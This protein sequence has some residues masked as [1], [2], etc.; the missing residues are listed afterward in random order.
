MAPGL[1]K[2]L[3]LLTDTANEAA[4]PVLLAALD[5]ADEA[6]SAGALHAI[7]GRRRGPGQRALIERWHRLSERWKLEISQQPRQI[8]AAVRHA[9]LSRDA[10][11]CPNGCS[12]L[13]SIREFELIPALVTCIEEPKHPHA[14]LVAQTLLS[15]CELLQEEITGPRDAARLQDPARVCDQILPN[16]EKA[17]ERFE[18]HGCRE[19]MEAFLML[20]NGENPTFK[21]LLADP[22][23]PAYLT[24]I[25]TLGTSGRLAV[26]RLI[27]NLL[28][29]RF[30]PSVVLQVVSRR[31]DVPFIRQL[32]KRVGT[33]VSDVLKPTLRR[34]ESIAWL[35]GSL[36][37]LDTLTESEQAAAVWLAVG[38]GMNRLRV[39]D[40]V[41]HVLVQGRPAGRRA[42]AAALREFGGAEANELVLRGLQDPDPQVQAHLLAQLRDRGIP[43]AISRLIQ[44]LDSRHEVVRNAAQSC[45]TEFN[46][47]RYITVFDLMEDNI[48]RST[49][50]LVMRI[51]PQ[52][53]VLLAEELKSRTRTRRLRALEAAVAMDAVQLVEPLII[54]LLTD[55]D[56]FVRAEA[57]RTLAYCDTPLARQSLE[58]AR[59][60]RSVA[61]REAAE[62]ALRKL[63]GEGRL[64]TAGSVEAILQQL[65]GSLLMEPP[66]SA[67]TG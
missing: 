29:T 12:A 16:L 66:T 38:S 10:V 21:R 19:V 54:V 60:D 7:L 33:G 4:V 18:H 37:L 20:I 23:H 57:A 2:T 48:R 1:E 39:F 24:M 47:N 32:L 26:M 61:V 58:Q 42:A 50:M 65:D 31:S 49:G 8:S 34:M 52:A 46:F 53:T 5:T 55:Q 43:G 67:A 44:L 62:L 64:T 56:H 17:V 45:L 41:R 11:L 15:L 51:D 27:L 63:S 14:Q 35:Q 59:N 36:S 3:Q 13:L 6:V 30:P 22:R 25:E 9:I 28:E 40:V